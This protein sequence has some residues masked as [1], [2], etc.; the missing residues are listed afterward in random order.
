MWVKALDLLMDQL[1]ITGLDFQDIS[2]ISGAGQVSLLIPVN[3]MNITCQLMD[4]LQQHGSVYWRKGAQKVLSTVD[5][6]KFLFLQLAN[7]FS[8]QDSPVWMDFS[9]HSYCDTME[10]KLGGP[11]V[12]CMSNLQRI[13]IFCNLPVDVC[14]MLQRLADLTG[15]RAYERFTGHQIAKVV[16][17]KAELYF[18]TEVFINSTIVFHRQI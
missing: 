18:N 6:T 7:C 13:V 5:P 1:K 10:K 3:Q 4:V 16:S 2:A 11:Q 12:I 17:E 8:V 14:V 9:T 15:S